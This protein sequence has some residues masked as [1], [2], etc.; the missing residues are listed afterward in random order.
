MVP[1]DN[2]YTYLPINPRPPDQP[3][4]R[5]DTQPVKCSTSA[6]V[7]LPYSRFTPIRSYTM[8][9][10]TLNQRAKQAARP[11]RWTA[12]G[13]G[14][15]SFSSRSS[16]CT[17]SSPVFKL[18]VLQHG[19]LSAM[20]EERI[21][22]TDTILPRRG[23]IY[24]SRGQLLAGNTTANDV[25]IDKTHLDNSRQTILHAI[26]DLFAPV[27]GQDPNALYPSEGGARPQYQGGE[28][29]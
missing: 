12:G 6:K 4:R 14:L 26:T 17:T 25:Y 8:A 15:C 13:C 18:Q 20:A 27:I 10:T 19:D 21:K 11:Q 2:H 16:P 1:L 9:Q 5:A 22:W 24:D 7:T 3:S 23:L 28:P 29:H